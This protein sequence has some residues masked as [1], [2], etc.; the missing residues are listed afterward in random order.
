MFLQRSRVPLF[1]AA[2]L[3]IFATSTLAAADWSRFRGENGS[4]VAADSVPTPTEWSESMNLRWSAPLPGPGKSCPIVLGD[5]VILTCWSGENPPDD[6]KRHLLCFDRN[7][8]KELW[9]KEIAPTTP[10][11]PFREM[12]TENG[13]ASHTPASDGERIFAFFGLGGVVAFDMDG[14]EQWRES[15]GEGTD[16]NRWGSAS[17]PILYKDLVIVA[18]ASESTAIVALDKKTGKE[19][20]R[21]EGEGLQSTWGTPVLADGGEG[22]QDLVMAVPGELWGMNPDTGKLRWYAEGSQSRN[23]CCSAVADGGVAYVVGGRDGGSMAVRAGGKG[24]ARES[25]MLWSNNSRGG[26]GTPV[27]ADGLLY[28]ITGGVITCL[29]A[30]TGKQVYEKRLAAPSTPAPPSQTDGET[31][32]QGFGRPG[33]YAQ[34]G[35]NSRG[36]GGGFRQQDYS[37]PVIADGKLYFVRR[38][39]D[40]YV[41]ATGREFMPLAV[42]KFAGDDG[43]FSASPAVSD[44][45]IF[46]R[47]SNKLYC[48]A[49]LP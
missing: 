27:V 46:I 22:K 37:S 25:Q 41:L 7:T 36:G 14:N 29:D 26:I 17:S 21:Q 39:G 20:W 24:D 13:Y 42:N 19:V 1:R 2:A 45:A 23:I 28:S 44:G 43:D 47:S 11:E 35:G 40:V 6:L 16:P 10:D 3:V 12:F 49:Q 33:E 31:K 18:A 4:G 30:E 15:V 48:V 38:G 8:G 32:V 9:A 5:R 34:A